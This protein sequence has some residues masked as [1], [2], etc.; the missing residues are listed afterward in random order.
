MLRTPTRNDIKGTQ[1][2]QLAGGEVIKDY[3]LAPALDQF[4]P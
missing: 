3:Y 4:L 2:F 1:V